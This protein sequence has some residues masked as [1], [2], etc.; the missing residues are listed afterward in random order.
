MA[1]LAL[2]DICGGN[3]N[4]RLEFDATVPDSAIR[5]T[6]KMTEV[7]AR[8][9]IEIFTADSALEGTANLS[10]DVTS[11]GRTAKELLEGLGGKLS[12]SMV[13]GQADVDVAKLVS[14]L[15]TGPVK[16]WDAARG[17]VTTFKALQCEFFFRNGGAYTNS[18]KINL[19]TTDLTGEGTIDMA[20]SA[21][22]MRMKIIDHPPA[23]K[24]PAEK[25]PSQS[26]AGAIVIKGPWSQPSFTLEPSKS[27]AHVTSPPVASRSAR[28]GNN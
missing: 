18:L 15:Q 27:S 9:C 7:S 8:T 3:G 28:L 5:V 14:R 1:D 11:K 13:A 22:D 17:S 21:L 2:F 24:T 10:A 20:G 12:V 6:G 25:K 19:G 26:L 23:K 16:G 4:G